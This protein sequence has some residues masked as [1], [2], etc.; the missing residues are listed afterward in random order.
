MQSQSQ[1]N[2][3]PETAWYMY[4]IRF[5]GNDPIRSGF[6]V[7][8]TLCWQCVLTSGLTESPR[9]CSESIA[10]GMRWLQTRWDLSS[11]LLVAAVYPAKCIPRDAPSVF[12]IGKYAKTVIWHLSLFLSPHNHTRR[13]CGL[14]FLNFSFRLSST[15][16]VYDSTRRISLKGFGVTVPFS[17]TFLATKHHLV[18]MENKFCVRT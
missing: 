2:N 16:I 17:G 10:Q 11:A 15:G 6:E 14:V 18:N 7:H 4:F 1:C 5:H 3:S 8:I 9:I 12:T 13:W